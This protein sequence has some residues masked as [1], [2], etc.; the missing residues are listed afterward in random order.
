M[1]KI[2]PNHHLT[3]K[4]VWLN[5]NVE[6]ALTSKAAQNLHSDS[7]IWRSSEVILLS[8]LCFLQQISSAD[9]LRAPC[10]AWIAIGK[11]NIV[12]FAWLCWRVLSCAAGIH[13]SRCSLTKA[14]TWTQ[15]ET[16]F[17]TAVVVIL[18]S[19]KSVQLT[20]AN[21]ISFFSLWLLSNL[22]ALYV[23]LQ[24]SRYF[25]IWVFLKPQLLD[26]CSSKQYCIS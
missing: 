17:P 11:A 3:R 8:E 9:S 21:N 23:Q 13:P 19:F 6:T 12:I 16:Y 22:T 14:E 2:F 26:S 18:S 20:Y 5:Q 7:Q 1:D 10:S 4:S 24:V 15:T 25:M